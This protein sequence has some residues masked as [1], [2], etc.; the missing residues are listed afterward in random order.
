MVF[1]L[2]LCEAEFGLKSES[3]VAADRWCFEVGGVCCCCCF[4]YRTSRL[5]GR[6]ILR[7]L[8]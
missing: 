4:W 1:R 3:N 7:R 2:S 6:R 8:V 5:R